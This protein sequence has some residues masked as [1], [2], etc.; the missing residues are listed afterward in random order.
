MHEHTP[1]ES[2]TTA[3]KLN[4]H[5]QNKK[6]PITRAL[7]QDNVEIARAYPKLQMEPTDS[8]PAAETS[9]LACGRK[10]SPS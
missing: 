5:K 7:A 3:P 4:T 9:N 6:Q 10:V 1:L 8:P 2:T